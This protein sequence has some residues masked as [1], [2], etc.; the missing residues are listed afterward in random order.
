MCDITD[1]RCNREVLSFLVCEVILTINL[2]RKYNKIKVNYRLERFLEV[3]SRYV[4]NS[5]LR[6][7][8]YYY[9]L[10]SHTTTNKIIYKNLPFTL[11]HLISILT[12]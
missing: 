8:I 3:T 12:H 2:S 6:G 4:I 10:L 11:K 7:K 5:K 9:T 1:A